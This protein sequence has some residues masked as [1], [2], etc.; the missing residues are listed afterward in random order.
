M[1]KVA[2]L[3]R[4]PIKSHGRETLRSVA[5]VAGQA[6]P[7]D[8]YWAV[9][10]D[11]TKHDGR[12]WSSCRNFMIGAR[13]PQLAGIWAAF[14]EDTASI[15]L[16]HQ[17]LGEIVFRPDDTAGGVQFMNWAEP[18]TKAS[19]V[20]P[21]GIVKSGTRGMTD[22]DFP[23]IS[24]MNLA[25]HAAVA[26][27]TGADLQV[28]R[29]RGNIWLDD[30]PAWEEFSWVGREVVIGEARFAVR[31]RIERCLHTAANPVTGIRDTDTLGVLNGSFGH[32]DFG[33]YAEVITGGR[34]ACGDSVK[35]L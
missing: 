28:E 30:L 22:T 23:S 25:S 11:L 13:T 6:M 29:W 20:K 27:A 1:T 5:L 24:I 8:R 15:C 19:S 21:S 10:H 33:V 26:A 17:D 3:W 12:T 9:T 32:Q 18:I 31:D 16:R 14:D 4:Y 2:D 7:W 35:V 34:I